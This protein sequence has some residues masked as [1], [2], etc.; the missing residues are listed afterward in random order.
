MV[1]SSLTHFH[2]APCRSAEASQIIDD[3]ETA[4]LMRSI[5][6]SLL[7]L[8]P[9]GSDPQQLAVTNSD[10]EQSDSDDRFDVVSGS[11]VDGAAGT[12]CDDRPTGWEH[13]PITL[14]EVEASSISGRS[15]LPSYL[16]ESS[17]AV[18]SIV[19]SLW[20]WGR[21]TSD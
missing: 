7:G 11:G 8:P 13:V 10:S 5:E 21:G 17:T 1:S 15:S 14:P 6:S 20:R 18:T 4:A 2:H 9:P 16:V 19:S 3:D 12:S